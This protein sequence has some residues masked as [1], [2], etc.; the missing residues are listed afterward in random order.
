M[1]SGLSR[2]EVRS[3]EEFFTVLT[4][5]DKLDLISDYGFDFCYVVRFRPSFASLTPEQFVDH[6]AHSFSPKFIVVGDDWSFGKGRSGSA[7]RLQELGEQRG[8]RSSLVDGVMLDSARVSTSAVKAAIRKPD[9]PLLHRLLGRFYSVSGRV[10]P[11]AR[12]GRALGFPTAN[13][14][15]RGIV[16]PPDGIYSAWI[17]VDGARVPSAVYI[18]PRPTYGGGHRVL[19]AHLLEAPPTGFDLYRKRIEVEFAD[20]IRGDKQFGSEEEL[21]AAIASDVATIRAKLDASPRSA[22]V[23]GAEKP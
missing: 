15:F 14:E 2:T 17:H 1:L 13:L 7:S 9:F 23:G 12:R 21:R 6:L 22:V 18:G 3:R 10:V 4:I 20:Y 8:I 16:L 11:G 19:E 5:R